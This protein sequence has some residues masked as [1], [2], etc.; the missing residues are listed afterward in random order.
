MQ[1]TSQRLCSQRV[2]S[3]PS[4]CMRT[5]SSS[6][7]LCTQVSRCRD[8]ARSSADAVKP[9]SRRSVAPLHVSCLHLGAP[10][11]PSPGQEL[12]Q[13][14]VHVASNRS[15]SSAADPSTSATACR[16]GSRSGLARSLCCL[17]VTA[18]TS[19]RGI[20]VSVLLEQ[21]AYVAFRRHRSQYQERAAG[22]GRDRLPVQFHAPGTGAGDVVSTGQPG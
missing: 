18:R 8:D 1:I 21:S 2:S 3:C 17:A 12:L 5:S 15:A 9:G 14:V 16:K 20:V 4:V 7:V 19:S 6:G 22:S 13:V 10:R 11:S